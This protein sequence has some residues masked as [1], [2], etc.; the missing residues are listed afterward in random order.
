MNVTHGL[1]AETGAPVV[2]ATATPRNSSESALRGRILT[3]FAFFLLWLFV[4]SLPL[5]NSIIV[6]GI[7]TAGRILGL[8]AFVAGLLSL[9]EVGKVR[10]PMLVHLLMAAYVAWASMTYFW[11]MADDNSL[12]QTVSY[13]QLL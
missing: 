1:R 6:P 5:E 4:F 13:V 10:P 12:E 2:A 3:S 9:M 11:S 8:A 7:G